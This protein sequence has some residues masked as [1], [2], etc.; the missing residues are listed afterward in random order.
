[1]H[2]LLL[3]NDV[4]ALQPFAESL[5]AAR[6]DVFEEDVLP[7]ALVMI[8][9]DAVDIVVA[10]VALSDAPGVQLLHAIRARNEELPVVFVTTWPEP[11]SAA[12]EALVSAVM[13]A[14]CDRAYRRVRTRTSTAP[15]AITPDE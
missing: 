9:A 13:I 3:D 2:A 15:P 4:A 6:I 11:N 1:M 7:R 5:R 10:N 8:D 12:D 14:A